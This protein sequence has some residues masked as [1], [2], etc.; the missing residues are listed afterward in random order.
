MNEIEKFAVLA[1]RAFTN[2]TVKKGEEVIE[3]KKEGE[4]KK[5]GKKK[6]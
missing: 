2:E 3:E 6:K 5:K 1:G 4:K